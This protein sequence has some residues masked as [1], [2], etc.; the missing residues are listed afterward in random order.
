MKLCK[1][2]EKY[3]DSRGNLETVLRLLYRPINYPCL[4]K[5][6]D[7]LC[8]FLLRD[9]FPTRSMDELR[10]LLLGAF[11]RL[12]D[13]STNTFLTEFESFDSLSEDVDILLIFV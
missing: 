2:V 4:L 10:F 8:E 13:S 6:N 12:Y 7:Y 9:F 11:I 3:P 1:L 5:A